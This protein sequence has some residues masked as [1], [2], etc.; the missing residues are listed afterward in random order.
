MKYDFD[1][2]LDRFHMRSAKWSLPDQEWI[3][4]GTADMDFVSPVEVKQAITAD[5]NIGNYGYKTGHVQAYFEALSAWEKRRHGI[6][7]SP[8]QMTFVPG[9][10]SGLAAVLQCV[11]QPGDQVIIQP[12]VYGPFF[13]IV[14]QNGRVLSENRL[15]FQPDAGWKMNF[16]DLEQRAKTAS[17][18]LLCSPHN[19][20]GRVWSREELRQVV[21]ICKRYGVYIGVD[22]IH[23]DITRP[24][25]PFLS[26]LEIAPDYADHI[27]E[28]MSASKTF[29]L[30]GFATACLVSGAPRQHSM[31]QKHLSDLM[32]SG[33]MYG[34][35][36]SETAYLHGDSWHAQ[37][38]T[39]IW[40]N[41]KFIQQ[42]L[43]QH[44]P[45]CVL[46]PLEGTYLC[47]LDARPLGRTDKALQE[48]LSQQKLQL[49]PGSFFGGEGYYRFNIAC[50]RPLLAEGLRRLVTAWG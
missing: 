28:G 24:E 38:L 3:S 5:L 35:L 39:Y 47:W 20:V 14:Q 23:H 15:I 22:Q 49:V 46:S 6:C 33:S 10:L 21:D 27:F 19:P 11:T 13:S 2:Y 43:S 25:Y 45:Q 18:L 30:A 40:E 9:V 44:L 26:L 12:P 48:T 42:F 37:V 1:R 41:Y 36:A 34:L 4:M 29:N 16:E 17:L 8:E 7:I 50:P 32:V 31:V